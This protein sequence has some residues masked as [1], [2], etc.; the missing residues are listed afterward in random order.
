VRREAVVREFFVYLS[1]VAIIRV[2][3]ERQRMIDRLVQSAA[4]GGGGAHVK[5]VSRFKGRIYARHIRQVSD[6]SIA[7]ELSLT[8]DVEDERLD[9][10]IPD[11]ASFKT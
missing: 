7:G 3:E 4:D 8:I 11:R 6:T 5:G 10:L 9:S 2:A 1:K